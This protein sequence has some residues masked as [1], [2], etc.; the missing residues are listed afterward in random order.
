MGLPSYMRSVVHRNVVTRRIPVHS[1][2]RRVKR[3][4]FWFVRCG[5]RGEWLCGSCSLGSRS[6]GAPGEVRVASRG[7]EI[8]SVASRVVNRKH[9]E[10]RPAVGKESHQFNRKIRVYK[11]SNGWKVLTVLLYFALHSIIC[12]HTELLDDI[13]NTVV[14]SCYCLMFKPY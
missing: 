11:L 3:L 7:Q 2:A 14:T 9:D 6:F 1:K 10:L 13:D 4:H 12:T 5:V 8:V